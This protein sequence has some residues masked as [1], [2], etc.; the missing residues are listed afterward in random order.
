MSG[1]ALVTLALKFAVE[2]RARQTRQAV[3]EIFE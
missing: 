2:Y 1:V 3:Q